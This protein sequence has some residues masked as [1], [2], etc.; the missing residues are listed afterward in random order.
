MTWV[1]CKQKDHS[2]VEELAGMEPVSAQE[3]IQLRKE[4]WNTGVYQQELPYIPFP[5]H[6]VPRPVLPY[7]NP[8]NYVATFF[9]NPLNHVLKPSLNLPDQ[10]PRFPIILPNR[11]SDQQ[12]QYPVPE[13]TAPVYRPRYKVPEPVYPVAQ[14]ALS[15]SMK[16]KDISNKDYVYYNTELSG[17]E[18]VAPWEYAKLMKERFVSSVYKHMLPNILFP[19]H[20]VPRPKPPPYKNPN[21]YVASFFYNPLNHMLKPSVDLPDHQPKFPVVL[22]N[23]IQSQPAEPSPSNSEPRVLYTEPKPVRKPLYPEPSLVYPEPKDIYPE[24]KPMN[25]NPRLVETTPVSRVAYDYQPEEYR[26]MDHSPRPAVYNANQIVRYGIH[27]VSPHRGYVRP[28]PLEYSARPAKYNLRRPRP[29]NDRSSMDDTLTHP[30]EYNGRGY[31][32][33]QQKPRPAR[34]RNFLLRNHGLKY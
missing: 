7:K 11:P 23:M 18:S 4:Q 8:N 20:G 34:I 1:C 13:Y 26:L 33:A 12:R 27:A 30:L 24:P 14:H 22:P 3:Y 21:N 17:M 6:G 2:S 16:A 29:V 25:Y 9:Y 19:E 28:R 5:E 31:N 32:V 15:E 10:P